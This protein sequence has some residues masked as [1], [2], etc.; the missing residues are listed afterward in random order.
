M[1]A[2]TDAIEALSPT[3]YWK[4]DETSGTTAADSGSGTAVPLTHV[5][6]PFLAVN[7]PTSSDK[8]VAYNGSNQQSFAAIS[9]AALMIS[10]FS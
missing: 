3:H 1:T 8:G 4:L 9:G 2:L 10:S 7:G 5:N 6:S